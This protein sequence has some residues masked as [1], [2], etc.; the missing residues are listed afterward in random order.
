MPAR[1]TVGLFA[2]VSLC[3]AQTNP[4]TT[5]QALEQGGALFQ[6]HCAVCHGSR[7]EGG[8]G[9][10]LTTGQFRRGNSE[11]QLFSA[12][13]NGLRGTEM[14]AVR[15]NDDEVWKMVAFVLH[16]AQSLR[17]T[18]LQANPSSQAR[19]AA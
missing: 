17:A 18:R 16:P 4:F 6:L 5:P 10:D 14:P 2:I 11:A 19:A 13:R 7:G 8:R 9:A 12:I 1:W 15:A 3:G